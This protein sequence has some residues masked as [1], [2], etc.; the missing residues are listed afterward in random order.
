MNQ[1]LRLLFPPY[2]IAALVSA[3]AWLQLGVVGRKWIVAVA[4]VILGTLVLETVLSRGRRFKIVVPTIM[5]LLLGLWFVYYQV[6]EAIEV[7]IITGIGDVQSPEL[8]VL[9]NLTLLLGLG[10]VFLGRWT[11]RIEE[12]YLALLVGVGIG[13]LVN[14]VFDRLSPSAFV[15]DYGES[16]FEWLDARWMP[17]ITRSNG[18]FAMVCTVSV[19]FSIALLIAWKDWR[20]ER[21]LFPLVCAVVI[22]AGYASIRCQFRAHL[23]TLLGG[24]VWVV[25]PSR[26]RLVYSLFVA[27]G[28]IVF[29][30]LFISDIGHS[31][32]ATINLDSI[33]TRMGSDT[34]G[35][36]SL[37]GRTFMWSYGWE[38]LLSG[39][40][41]LFGDGPRLRD[42]SPAM[43]GVQDFS[44]RVGF[45]SGLIDLV[46]AH[47]VLAFIPLLVG[48]GI[49]IIL[50][51]RGVKADLP[52]L[53]LSL[54]WLTLWSLV[55]VLDGGYN[56]SLEA[57]FIALFPV[58]G[59]ALGCGSG[60]RLLRRKDESRVLEGQARAI[61]N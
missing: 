33:L 18:V 16:R 43:Y 13:A 31:F 19:S 48:W 51:I 37:S 53:Q 5:F 12:R 41:G 28:F 42:S 40:A 57:H 60:A 59:A 58:L 10:V 27:L 45:H 25:L 50:F 30:F 21:R 7:R 52:S 17:P 23:L 29:P 36:D 22:V 26:S 3:V 61:A 15:A 55:G 49:A 35:S 54:L 24:I 56:S 11:D 8:F 47:G 34:A 2:L 4:L 9:Q 14:L 1:N 6:R 44:F 20:L 39:N 32:L 38:R 46:V